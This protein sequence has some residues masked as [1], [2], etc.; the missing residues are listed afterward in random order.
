MHAL[1]VVAHPDP[2][3]LTHRVAAHLAEGVTLSDA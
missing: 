3:S 1:I 2:Q